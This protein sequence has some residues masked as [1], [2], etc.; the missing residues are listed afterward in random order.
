MVTPAS[1]PMGVGGHTTARDR[2]RPCAVVR[3]P[4]RVAPCR[5]GVGSA[6]R[7]GG[8]GLGGVVVGAGAQA[9]ERAGVER[10]GLGLVGG[11]VVVGGAG[12]GAGL[13]LVGGVL[14]TAARQ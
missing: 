11:V 6:E 10:A 5:R 12:G 13:G 2:V 9:G 1:S 3:I 7:A 8:V 4:G 14:V